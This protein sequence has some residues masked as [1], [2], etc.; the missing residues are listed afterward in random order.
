MH[1]CAACR[2]FF[3]FLKRTKHRKKPLS[4]LK[5]QYLKLR[6]R[7]VIFFARAKVVIH[8][9][10]LQAKRLEI[11]SDQQGKIIEHKQGIIDRQRQRLAVVRRHK[12]LLTQIK[13]GMGI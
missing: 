12:R 11:I 13:K 7:K 4:Q 8:D 3:N 5:A 1:N 6:A 2:G 9:L 10:R